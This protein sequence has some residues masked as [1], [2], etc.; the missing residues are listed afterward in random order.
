MYKVVFFFNNPD[1][2]CVAAILASSSC[3]RAKGY[4]GSI[5]VHGGNLLG[6]AVEIIC[7]DITVDLDTQEFWS[8]VGSF[9]PHL[10]V[11][12]TELTLQH[13]ITSSD[14]RTNRN[15]ENESNDA[16]TIGL[17]R[18]A[19]SPIHASVQS[20]IVSCPRPSSTLARLLF[21]IHI[22]VSVQRATVD[23]NSNIRPPSFSYHAEC[24]PYVERC[25][26]S[27]LF[28]LVACTIFRLV[29]H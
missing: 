21:T 13:I 17:V 14:P 5:I 6:T 3:L 18:C 26:I 2:P 10:L 1:N 25:R 15:T 11:P 9:L 27:E 24:A 4:T 19:I 22:S 7:R 12:D 20:A 28:A 8:V 23:A 29:L 16:R